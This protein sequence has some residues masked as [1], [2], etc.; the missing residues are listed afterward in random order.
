[1]SVLAYF[2]STEYFYN[3]AY[4]LPVCL[5]QILHG[6]YVYTAKIF[7]SVSPNTCYI[8]TKIVNHY[9]KFSL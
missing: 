2:R 7:N 4:Y 9:L 5:G 3:I 6:F 8:L 1:M